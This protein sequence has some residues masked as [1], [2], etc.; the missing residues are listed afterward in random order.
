[1]HIDYGEWNNHH[2]VDAFSK[3]PEVKL[4]S[5]TT[6][7]RTI[8]VLSDIFAMF[9]LPQMLV[10]DNAPQFVSAEFEDFLHQ[11]HITHRA[12]PPYHLS[13]NGIA[14]NMVKNVKYHLKKHGQVTSHKWRIF[15]K[16]TALCHTPP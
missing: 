12:S 15:Y 6:S 7:R 11:N 2:L 10:S 13:P 3:W 16:H 9:G 4:V 8:T 1:M 14:E 5:S